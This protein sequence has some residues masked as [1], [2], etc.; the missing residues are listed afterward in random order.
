MIDF[1][2]QVLKSFFKMLFIYAF[3]LLPREDSRWRPTQKIK[4][5]N[6]EYKTKVK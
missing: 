4:P 6:T 5:I 2:N 1:L 3:H